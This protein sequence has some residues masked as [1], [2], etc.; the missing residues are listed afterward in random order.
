MKTGGEGLTKFLCRKGIPKEGTNDKGV[1]T[2][3]HFGSLK[4]TYCSELL[5]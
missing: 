1:L 4:D 3:T 5:I 2:C